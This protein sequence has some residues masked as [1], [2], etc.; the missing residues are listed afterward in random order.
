LV[1][2][3]IFFVFQLIPGDAADMYCGDEATP[4][5]IARTRERLGLD[6][7][8]IVQ[9]TKYLS[10]LV[11]G[12]FGKSIYFRGPVIEQIKRSYPNTVKLAVGAILL[13]TLGGLVLGTVSAV[14][15]GTVID[16]LSGVLA[17][18]GISIPNFWL[19]LLLMY[20]FSLKLGI[21]PIAGNA[22]WKHYIM[23]VITLS[24][25]SMAFITRM[26]RSSLLETIEADYVRTARAKGLSEKATIIRHALRNALIPTVSVVGLR[27]GYM[28][29]G[30]VIIEQVFVWPG[31]GRLFVLAVAQR[32]VAVVQGVLLIFAMSFLAVNLLVDVTYTL[33]DPR[34]RYS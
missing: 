15:H 2:T 7:P 34:I 26:T 20:V 19:G 11:R 10:S 5:E 33:I 23:P 22:T 6:K 16:H 3:V 9:Y 8:A 4:E 30:A 24:A 32:D 28:L 18:V 25:F 29:G 13:A 12:D 27:F 1:V 17:I 31:M 14:K 21:L